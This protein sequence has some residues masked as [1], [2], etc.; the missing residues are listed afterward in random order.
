MRFG[1]VITAMVTP[2]DENQNIDWGKVRNLMDELIE[3][4]KTHS[5]V[6]A[7]TTGESAALSHE[8]KI[9]LFDFTVKY[10]RG[11]TRIIAATGTNDTKQ[12]IL[13]SKQAEILGVDGLLIVTPYYNRPSQEG[14]YQHYKAIASEVDLPIILY[15]V[16]SR[17]GVNLEAKT[18]L[19]L[20]EIPTIVGVKECAGLDQMSEIII[21]A[22]EGFEV[23]SGDD[24][25]TLPALAIGATGVISVA[26]HLVGEE[27][28][29]MV[30]SFAKG[31]HTEAAHWHQKLYPLFKGLFECPHRV[32][33]PA[34]VKYMLR[35]KGI[36]VGGVRLPLIDVTPAE[37]E[38]LN[39]LN[40]L[41]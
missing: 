2:F 32:P 22:R 37:A 20:S 29:Q 3:N 34:P 1:R 16:P 39:Q 18:V 25:L 21:G 15:N 8:E 35:Q 40:V 28:N 41:H 9:E 10:A 26:S 17:T 33:S 12:T 36:D 11:R 7:G 23:F 14:M 6:I 27:M 13:L 30:Y 19:R 38:Y 4:Q 31:N 24:S 5:L